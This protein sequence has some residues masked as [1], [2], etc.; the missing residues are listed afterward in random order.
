MGHCIIWNVNYPNPNLLLMSIT[1]CSFSYRYR[2]FV[3]NVTHS[4]IGIYSNV[5]I[6]INIHTA[7]YDSSTVCR[8]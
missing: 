4:K 3:T 6:P 8:L 5:C 7:N 2:P 1:V